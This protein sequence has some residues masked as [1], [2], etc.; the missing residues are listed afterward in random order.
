MTAAPR[1]LVTGASGFIGSHIAAELARR[2]ADVIALSRNPRPVADWDRARAAMETW[3]GR[4]GA[5]PGGR[6]EPVA[7]DLSFP[8]AGERLA[9][10]LE[11]VTAVIHAAARLA[12]GD[13]EH[14]RDTLGPTRTLCAAMEAL[15]PAPLLVLVSS[16][17]VYDHAAIRASGAVLD[18]DSPLEADPSRRDAYARAKLGQEEIARASAARGLPLRVL[19]PAYV[20]GPG[21]LFCPYLGVRK[22]PVELAMGDG[23]M[24]L[25]PVGACAEA[26]ALAAL[27]PA[28]ATPETFNAVDA[29]APDRARWRAALPE[30]E[31][32]KLSV[33]VPPAA[34]RAAAA[35]LATAGQGHRAPGLLR[36]P[37]Y[38]ARFLG[39][40]VRDDRLRASFGWTPRFG[41]EAVAAMQG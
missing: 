11:G 12:G 29:D 9:E 2:G 10:L 17:S 22:G 4:E 13:A 38:A 25:I 19:R 33:P 28:P 18:E 16:F 39:T 37:V 36:E 30:G 26:L 6:I 27:S 8:A 41:F 20:Y 32:A 34:L 15:D 5:A 24:A 7:C 40:P 14:A 35:L 3:T 31:R 1:I 21:R 23:P